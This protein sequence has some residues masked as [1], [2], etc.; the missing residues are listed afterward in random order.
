MTVAFATFGCKV[1]Q[2]DT[3]AMLEAFL[4]RGWHVRD[5]SDICDA[6]V[7]NTCTVTGT[8]A[9]KSLRA[10]RQAARRNPAAAIVVAGCLSQQEG[11][12]MLALPGVRLVLGTAQRA[13]APELL[14]DALRRATLLLAVEQ[15]HEQPFEQSAVTSHEAHTRAVL[16]IQEGCENHCS[17]CVIPSVRG[18]VRSRELL[19]VREEAVRLSSA[20]YLEIVLT[21]IH[22]CSYGRDLH[23]TN[24]TDALRAVCEAPGVRRVRLGSLEPSFI[25]PKVAEAFAELAALCPQFHLSLQSGSE[26]V[27]RGMRRRYTPGRY[28]QAVEA[29]REAMPG[30][31]ITTDVITGFP[32]EDEEAFRETMAFSRSIGFS[33]MHV[34][35]YS[36]REGTAA[37]SLPGAVPVQARRERAARLIA[38]GEAMEREYAFA[39]IGLNTE[40]LFEEDE[41]GL[42]REYVRARVSGG[43][44]GEI[45]RVRITDFA[46]GMLRGVAE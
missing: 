23:Q 19:S 26:R 9:Q 20:G 7:V 35:P 8:G 5:F 10:V 39:Q 4:A 2:Y 37:V 21:G 46:D 15:L 34:F 28:A 17:Y 6:Y 41:E 43:K 1:N 29:L 30:C 22:L 11:A 32:G 27:L 36:E 3:Q 38:L 18:P 16:K 14:E 25:T 24:L 33:R 13:R 40:V 45:A 12:N 42:T 44:T 31:A